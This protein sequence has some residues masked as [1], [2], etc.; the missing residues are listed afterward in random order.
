MAETEWFKLVRKM[1]VKHKCSW[2][3]AIK[4]AQKSGLY[5]KMKK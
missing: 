2:G 3:E 5:T 1:Y 4:Y